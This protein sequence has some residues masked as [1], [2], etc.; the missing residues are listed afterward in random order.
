MA[1][2]IAYENIITSNYKIMKISSKS[3]TQGLFIK[4]AQ[5]VIIEKGRI[6]HVRYSLSFIERRER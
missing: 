3:N 2:G 6:F 4:N 5:T 1:D